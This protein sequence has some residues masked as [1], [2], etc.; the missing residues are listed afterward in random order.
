MKMLFGGAQ[1][2]QQAQQGQRQSQSGVADE[3]DPMLQMMQSLLGNISGDPNAPPADTN[4]L[5][6]SS[7]DIAKMTGLPSF[8]TSM[9]MGAKQA[10]PPTPEQT[11][12]ERL[13]KV[14]RLV[15]SLLIGI[16]T[17]FIVDRSVSMFGNSPPRPATVQNP[18]LIFVMSQ[19][20]VNGARSVLGNG[21]SATRG[22]KR[23][24][25]YGRDVASDA[26]VPLFMLGTYCWW[27]GYT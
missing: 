19:L 13:W 18:L 15:V 2:G 9:F 1:Q 25:Q 8:L 20:T 26:A 21:A 12:Q 5:P 7:D 14:I 27:S 24:L 11:K 23:Y 10:V 4:S 22:F 17:V 3:T 16:Y 6:L